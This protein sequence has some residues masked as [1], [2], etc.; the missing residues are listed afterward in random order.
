MNLFYIFYDESILDVKVYYF[1]FECGLFGV[2]IL[3]NLKVE[4]CLWDENFFI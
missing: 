4:E 3:Y 1:Y 2:V